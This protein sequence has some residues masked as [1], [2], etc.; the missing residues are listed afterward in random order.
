MKVLAICFFAPPQLTPQ[1]IQIGRQ[2]Y[3]LD[4]Q[5]TLIHG[6]DANLAST[7]N[8]YPDFSSKVSSFEVPSPPNTL[9]GRMHRAA[10]R[11][12]PFYGDAPDI[13]RSWVSGAVERG[14]G[15]IDEFRPDVLASFGVPM[16]DHLVG[17]ALAHQS[18]LPWLAHF[19]DP[20]ADNAFHERSK[21]AAWVNRRQERA[22]IEHAH[23]TLFT[24]SRTVDL[25][26][27]KYPA[28]WRDRVAVVPHAWDMGNFPEPPHAPP[29]D[30]G[31]TVV[32]HIGSCYGRR[33]PEPLFEAL[34][35]VQRTA[36]GLLSNVVFEFIG[37]VSPAFQNS[38]LLA[39]LPV[40]LVSFLGSVTYNESLGL[41]TAADALL[42]IDAHSDSDSVFLPS[43]LIEYI[44]T[45]K[46]IWGIT[47][48]GTSA[49]LIGD[50]MGFEKFVA[51][52]KDIPGIAEMLTIGLSRLNQAS[53][54]GENSLEIFERYSP[55]AVAASLRTELASV[56]GTAI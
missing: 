4:A 16:S 50:W 31:K 19:S 2:L 43:K 52:P 5:V 56:V 40:G 37:Y 18:G 15:V 25:V 26:M 30:V 41:M 3:H 13:Y 34:V 53:G 6:R 46:P 10:M 55:Q 1:A 23:R 49:E 42:V 29:R 22:V 9:K 51:S 7:Y 17:L 32:R 48:Q 47:P 54:P 45:R 14:L 12:L 27:S 20:W 11:Y 39:L 35:S 38:S 28:S 44:G 21:L 24:S 33:S 36:P 8:Q